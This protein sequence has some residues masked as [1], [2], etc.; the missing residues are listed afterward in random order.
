LR[1]AI[2]TLA[3][4][5]PGAV[6]PVTG[7]SEALLAFFFLAAEP[8]ANVVLPSPGFPTNDAMAESF[9]IEVRRYVLR[10]ENQFRI[11]LEEIQRLVDRNT[12]FVLVNTPHNPTGAVLSDAEMQS[13]HDFCAD[14][15]VQLIADEVYHPIYHGPPVQSAARLPHVT[16]VSDFSKALCLSGLRVGW[17]IDRDAER[18][19][20]YM[21]ARNYFTITNSSIAERLAAFALRHN[22]AIY[23]RAQRVAARS[24]SLLDQMFAEHADVIRWI[25]P[26]GGM[27][28]F[29]WLARGGDTRDFCLRLARRGVLMVPGDCFGR[30]EH[31]R[32]GFAAADSGFQP[33]IERFADFLRGK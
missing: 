23:S 10:A 17:I 18:L 16:V 20:R 19:K 24:L 22:D 26:S 30:P 5:L 21:T 11:D 33:A 2:A 31:F 13:L 14:R 4:V 7:A 15:G 32:L 12:R 28:A 8:D 9:G 27:T 29:P 1:E 3:G 25:R 6:Q